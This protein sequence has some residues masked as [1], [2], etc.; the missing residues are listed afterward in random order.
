MKS[1]KGSD[2]SLYLRALT[3]AALV[4]AAL[5]AGAVQHA[6]SDESISVSCY[7]GDRSPGTV[8][9]FDVQAAAAACNDM[10]YDCRSRC[11]ACYHDFDYVDYVCVDMQGNTFLK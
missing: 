8:V 9:V 7:T 3:A 10:Y 1:T 4:L 5:L 2:G 11:I 6:A